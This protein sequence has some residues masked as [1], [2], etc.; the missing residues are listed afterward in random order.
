MEAAHPLGGLH[1]PGEP[2]AE[3]PAAGVLGADEFHRH[4][5]AARRTAE[6]HLAHS[7]RT[8]PPKEPVAADLARVTGLERIHRRSPVVETEPLY[9]SYVRGHSDDYALC[10]RRVTVHH[11]SHR[12]Q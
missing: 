3:L 4:R 12:T 2:A 7:A 10:P 1:L 5:T 9:S 8:Q 11:S 6:E